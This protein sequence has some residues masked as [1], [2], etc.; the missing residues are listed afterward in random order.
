MSR[1]SRYGMQYSHFIICYIPP[2]S[3]RLYISMTFYSC[4]YQFRPEIVD[5]LY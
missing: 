4:L 5:K 2:I 3:M 1:I